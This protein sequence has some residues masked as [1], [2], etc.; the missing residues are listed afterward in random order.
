MNVNIKFSETEA[1]K[2][3]K[4]YWYQELCKHEPIL[5]NLFQDSVCG[6]HMYN[7]EHLEVHLLPHR[8]KELLTRIILNGTPAIAHCKERSVDPEE[9][10]PY[11]LSFI[12]KDMK[13]YC[14]GSAEEF[15]E[16][17][18]SLTEEDK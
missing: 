10:D 11:E 5:V 9:S 2:P 7:S 16:L 1:L 6:I 12:Y 15:E 14:I 3:T 8:W 4:F 13:F 17:G 18:I